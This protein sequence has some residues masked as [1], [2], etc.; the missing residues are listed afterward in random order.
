MAAWPHYYAPSFLSFGLW[1]SFQLCLCFLD[2]WSQL[3]DLSRS[4]VGAAAWAASGLA[5]GLP[6]VV[7]DKV[8]T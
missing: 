5:A 1:V 2:I 4:G 3:A 8:S 7:G 6:V